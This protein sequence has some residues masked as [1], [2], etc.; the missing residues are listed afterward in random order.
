MGGLLVVLGLVFSGCQTYP[1][2]S[3][4]PAPAPRNIIVMIN[5]G[6][7]WGTWDAAAY[8]QYGSREGAPYADFPE[9]YGVTTYPLNTSNQPTGDDDQTIRYDPVQAWDPTPVPA[10]DLPFVGYQYVASVA[11]DSAAAGT[12]L[13]SGIKSYNNAVNYDNSGKAV[14]FSTLW[15]KRSGRATGVV[16]TVPF[17]HAT[18]A[19]FAAQNVSR[20]NYHQIAHQMLAQGHLDLVMGAG[21][22]G[23]SVNG[24]P[25]GSSLVGPA[26]EGC[27][28]QWEYVSQE[29]WK[30]L[31]AGS[32]V[33]KNPL[34][35]WKLIRRR[36]DFVALAAGSVP[37]DRPL[38]GIPSVAR[39]LQQARQVNVVGVDAKMPSQVKALTSVPDLQT[40]TRGALEFLSRRSAEG[41]F[42]MVEGGATDWAAHTSACGT[43]WHYGDCT[44]EPQYGRLIEESVD[45]NNAVSAVVAWIESN[46][47]WEQNLLIVTTDHDN[48][49]PLGPSAQRRA[50]EPVVNNGR[51]RMPGISFRP[52]GN[53]SNALV[54]LWAKGAGAELFRARVRGIDA[55]YRDHVKLNDG[56]YIDN[57]DVATVLK[58]VVEPR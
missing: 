32:A 42:L 21:G 51:A 30:Q 29:D 18:P 54:P 5:D 55:G 57:T 6:A 41:L 24:Q 45:F 50:F 9:R 47:G 7:G 58:M 3:A 12:A 35:P 8:W 11:T 34:G 26:S 25:C 40:M 4:T 2:T 53:H 39:T 10:P 17:S 23:F 36:E 37:T 38:I 13:S 33:G 27:E 44:D 56:R 1:R 20:N 31:V 46:G 52:T 14:S 22:P 15:A 43:E 48:S 49:M 19:A 28:S 16:T